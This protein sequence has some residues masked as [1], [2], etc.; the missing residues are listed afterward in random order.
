M[1]TILSNCRVIDCTGRPRLD[2]AAIVIE[3]NR[4][5]AIGAQSEVLNADNDSQAQVIDLKGMTVMPG[6]RNLHVHLSLIYPVGAQPP[7]WRETIPWR[8]NKNAREALEAGVTL[9]RT[10]GE[11]NHYDIGLRKAID[12]GLATGPRLVCAGRGI[13]PTGGHGSDSPWYI[14]ADGADDF[15]K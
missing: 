12:M 13:T 3:G 15:R 10:T 1:K 9:C 4:I 8:M 14:E 5:H 7:G 11:A 6:R 2:K